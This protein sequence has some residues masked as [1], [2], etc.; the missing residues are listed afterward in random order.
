MGMLKRIYANKKFASVN[1]DDF[2]YYAKADRKKIK[3]YLQKFV[4]LGGDIPL[5]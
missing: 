3:E 1:E 5:D 4:F 2:I